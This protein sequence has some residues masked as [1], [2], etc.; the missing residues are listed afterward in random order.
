VGT[1]GGA[2]KIYHRQSDRER[3]A[4][5]ST[6]DPRNLHGPGP[7]A[8]DAGLTNSGKARAGRAAATS[9]FT[10]RVL[11]RKVEVHGR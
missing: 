7:P 1:N 3:A 5:S 6:G 11:M 2:F 4:R 8:S 9:L 10:R